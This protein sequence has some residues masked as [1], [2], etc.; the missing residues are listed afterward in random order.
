MKPFNCRIGNLEVK[1]NEVGG[2]CDDKSAASIVRWWDKEDEPDTKC[3]ITIAYWKRDKEGYELQFVG[4]R[5]LDNEVDW[6]D[7]RFLVK[8]GQERLTEYFN[9]DQYDEENE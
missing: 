7:F 8:I 3:C 4:D 9:N 6:P 1:S 5:P 2:K